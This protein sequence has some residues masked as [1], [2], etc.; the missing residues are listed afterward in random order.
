LSTSRIKRVLVVDDSKIIRSLITQALAPLGVEIFE[1]VDGHQALEMLPDVKPDMMTLDVEM[2]VLNGYETCERIH[3]CGPESPLF[4]FRSLPIVMV[5]TTDSLKL[6]EQGF[7]IGITDFVTKP[8]TASEIRQAV[9]SVLFPSLE[10]EALTLLVVEDSPTIMK[11]VKHC[12]TS[13]AVHLLTATD[14]VEAMAV[15]EANPQVDLVLTDLEMPNMNGLELCV[16]IRKTRPKQD[17]PIIFL[18]SVSVRS[19]ILQAFENGATDYLSKP[20]IREELLARL[21]IHFENLTNKKKLKE[22]KNILE[23]KFYLQGEDLLHTQEATI[24]VLASLAEYRDPETGNHIRRTQQYVEVLGKAILAHEKY[25]KELDLKW[26]A[27]LT[28]AAPLH[29]I[30]KVSITDDILLK[31]AKL[32]SEEFDIM[33][34]HASRGCDSLSEAEQMLG[35]NNFL[36]LAAELAGSH[37]EKW[38]GS[39]YPLGLAGEDIPLSG[40]IMAVADVYDALVSKRVYKEGMPHNK[41]C[42]IILDGSGKHFDPFLITLFVKTQHQF[43]EIHQALKD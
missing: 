21:Q 35:E 1:A 38:D 8:F 31:P 5:T 30:G 15:M 42:E 33:K 17:F 4:A 26:L 40:R 28:L 19:Y 6:R 23:H 14:G 7:E 9:Q 3:S 36:I 27:R 11:L 12:L 20:F 43:F 25:K 16:E 24:H 32:T 29:D 2:P 37:H 18:T 41:A 39:G 10:V 22:R 34:T 13:V